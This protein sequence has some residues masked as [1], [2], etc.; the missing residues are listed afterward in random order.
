VNT[1]LQALIEGARAALEATNPMWHTLPDTPIEQNQPKPRP[2]ALELVARRSALRTRV[3]VYKRP[4]Y[5]PSCT[6][7][8]EDAALHRAS[9]YLEPY[10]D[11]LGL[12][13]P[14]VLAVTFA[15]LYRNPTANPRASIS[16]LLPR[17]VLARAL[18][19]CK[20]TISNWLADDATHAATVRQFVDV[21]DWK[22]SLPVKAKDKPTTKRTV[23]GGFL[24]SVGL[25]ERSTAPKLHEDDYKH[26]W[27]DL[28][29]DKANARTE[30][31]YNTQNPLGEKR[32]VGRKKK[33]VTSS[34]PIKEQVQ[35][36]TRYL[37]SLK[38]TINQK[39]VEVFYDGTISQED[40]LLAVW[41]AFEQPV[42]TKRDGGAAWVDHLAVAISRAANDTRNIGAWQ[43]AAW[44]VVKSEYLGMIGARA[45][46]YQALW[47]VFVR[48]SD[49]VGIQNRA[50]LARARMNQNGWSEFVQGVKQ[51]F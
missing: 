37:D 47:D 17:W 40:N 18:G 12:A 44:V 25:E 42:K 51:N 27:R 9:E 43:K 14:V 13:F 19:V 2:A 34:I 22:T 50:A 5:A 49:A 6:N 45:V 3:K 30:R 41:D 26:Q 31:S 35:F 7:T 11:Q 15:A 8:R 23:S 36:I 39:H 48:Q 29:E 1:K 28:E 32:R 21:R 10:K 46:M 33:I 38:T 20:G 16:V 24:F 4:S